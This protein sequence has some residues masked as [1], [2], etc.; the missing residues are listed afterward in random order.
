MLKADVPI[1]VVGAGAWG[2]ALARLLANKGRQVR[3][4]ENFPDYT[5]VLRNRRENPKFLP[6]VVIPA[7]V[8]ITSDPGQAVAGADLVVMVPPAQHFREVAQRLVAAGAK[9]KWVLSASKGIE[10]GSLARMSEIIREV[11]PAD[12]VAGALSGPSHAEEVGRDLP[13][14]VVAAAAE[15]RAAEVFQEAFM[16]DA[17]RVYTSPDLAGVE[18]GGALK[19]IIALA[20]GMV[21]GLELGDNAKAALMTRGLAEISRMGAALRARPE[22]FAGLSGLGDLVVTCTSRLSRNRRV[23]EALGRGRKLEEI[24]SG[25]EM[26]AEGVETTRSTYQLAQRLG[27]DLPITE[28]MYRLLFSGV[29]PDRAVKELMQR[30]RKA[31]MP[32]ARKEEPA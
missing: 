31:E 32:T 14:S 6:G 27:V 13:T 25:M 10:H 22:T 21:D 30:P 16:T 20:A 28:Q 12:V 3:L 11:F 29:P 17:F 24:L 8:E 18:L 4:W 9:P 19:N 15:S 2:T 23:G 5:E 7:S 1:A 26:V